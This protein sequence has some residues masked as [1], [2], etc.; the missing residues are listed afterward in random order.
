MLDCEEKVLEK[1]LIER[2][3]SFKLSKDEINKKVYE[4]DLPNG[5]KVIQNSNKADFNLIN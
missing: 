1:R 2:W 3:E 5:I 4:N